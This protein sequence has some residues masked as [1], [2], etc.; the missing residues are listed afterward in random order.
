VAP[1][2]LW[3]VGIPFMF[4]PSQRAMM[5][6]VAADKQGQAAGIGRCAQQMGGTISMTVCG[7][8]LA[9]TGAFA[10]VFLAAACLSLAVLAIDWRV[11]DD[12]AM[13]RR[14]A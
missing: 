4:G 8:L 7:T 14:A 13:R 2:V 6:A 12:Q 5:N 9:M 11:R 1:M 3:G 10:A